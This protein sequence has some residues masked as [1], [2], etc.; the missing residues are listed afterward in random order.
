MKNK[1]CLVC[2]KEFRVYPNEFERRKTC[3]KSCQVKYTLPNGYWLGKKRPDLLKT[4]AFKTMFK[5]G[6][7]PP[8]KGDNTFGFASHP[9]LR[10]TGEAWNKGLRGYTN[11]GTFKSGELHP[12]WKGGIYKRER[13]KIMN[14]PSYKNWRRLVKERDNYTCVL[15]GAKEN[16]QVDHIKGWA[17]Y[18]ELRLDINNARTLCVGC[19]INTPN[20]GGKTRF[21]RGG[22]AL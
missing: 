1:N 8:N 7:I 16:L 21:V 3:S 15:C 5:K 14:S 19:H 4:N 12:H 22:D 13:N 20:Y 6:S 2:N 9:E 17:D 10:Y 11:T 18:P